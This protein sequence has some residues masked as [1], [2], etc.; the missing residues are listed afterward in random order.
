MIF[1]L[2]EKFEI[3]IRRAVMQIE[4]IRGRCEAERR[5][6]RGSAGIYEW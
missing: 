5:V 4:K 3:A 1:F 6:C 2:A